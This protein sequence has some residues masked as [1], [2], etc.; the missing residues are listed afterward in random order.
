MNRTTTSSNARF[1]YWPA[2]L[3]AAAALAMLSWPAR[4]H[5]QLDPLLFA[6]R[7][8]PT[9]IVVMDTSFQMLNDGWDGRHDD[10]D[11]VLWPNG[12]I[13][14]TA[15]YRVSDASHDLRVALNLPP[16]ATYY[17]RIYRNF[18]FSTTMPDATQKYTA[19]AI[20]A[21]SD[22]DPRYARFWS[23]T[24][25]E[26]ARLGI[27]DA[28]EH[29]RGANFRWGLY[30]LRQN[31]PALR[32]TCDGPVIVPAGS[33]LAGLTDTGACDGGGLLGI[34][35]TSVA[36][37]NST[38]LS[39]SSTLVPPAANT[40]SQ[41]LTQLGD[42]RQFLGQ[43][44]PFDSSAGGPFA[45]RPQDLIPA[46]LDTQGFE[47]RP[48]TQLLGDIKA[49]ATSAITADTACSNCRNT[50]VVLV[51]AGG[52]HS[53]NP[54]AVAAEFKALAAGG[55]HKVP[56]F[57]VWV[58]PNQHSPNYATDQVQ[59]QTIAD[60]SGGVLIRAWNRPG[61]ARAVNLA[62][63]AGFSRPPD[64]NLQT[65]RRSSEFY[66]VSPVVGTVNLKDARDAT[67]AELP[68][69]TVYTASGDLIPQRN[70]FMLTAGF[71][72]GLAD[73]HAFPHGPGF[74]GRLR[75]FRVFKPVPDS[76][77]PSGY[78]F[79]KDGTPLW[80]DL[81]GRPELANLARVPKNPDS[82]NIYTYIPNVGMVAF[83]PEN[84]AVIEPFLGP[85]HSANALNTSNVAARD[86]ISYIRRQPLGAVIGST[87]AIMDP[88]SLDPPPD[89]DYGRPDAAGTYA[90]D[91][92]DRRSII[93]IGANDGMLHAIDARTGY[94][95]W[96]FI[97]FNLLPKLRAIYEQGQPV[98]QFNYYMD[99][100]PKIAEIKTSDGWR[101]YLVIGEGPG[102]TFYQAFDVTEAGMDGP[103]PESDDFEGVLASFASP[104]RV[105]FKWAFPDYRSFDTTYRQD[106]W[107]TST[108]T[109]AGTPT[110]AT[111]GSVYRA[112]GEL[113]T[114]ATM[115][116]KTVGQT[117]SD[118]AVGALNADRSVNVAMVGSGYYPIEAETV[119]PGRG[120]VSAGHAFYLIRMDTGKLLGNAGGGACNGMGCYDV[121][122]DSP[123][124]KNALQADPTVTGNYGSYIAK[125]AYL[126]DLDGKYYR[127]EFD[128]TG[129]IKTPLVVKTTDKPI[130]A[131]SALMYVGSAYRYVFFMT[132][133]D[134][135]PTSP[136]SSGG[137]GQFKLFG[138]QDANGV[139][140]D[141][142]DPIDLSPVT[143]L[144][145]LPVGERPS[146][147]P[148]V[149]GEIVFFTTTVDVAPACSTELAG[150]PVD[151][152]HNLY[153][154]TYQGTGAY[155]GTGVSSGKK[156]GGGN[157]SVLFNTGA[158]RA[159]APFIVDQH[160]Y[161]ATSGSTGPKVEAFGDPNDFNNGV[162]QVGVRILSW[163]EI[164]R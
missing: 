14:D 21:I 55:G 97:P 25:Y 141:S 76:T 57:V 38:G 123:S 149:A 59:L 95:V 111:P 125:W 36:G 49:A 73:A 164:R 27:R 43:T 69:H 158:G 144:G 119:V 2:L 94:E 127:F 110:D 126:G 92:K 44:N 96:A 137:T 15:T 7:V 67:G 86:L 131:S 18:Q 48:L 52:D 20:E 12:S 30:K 28:V 17:R 128:E 143:N 71:G 91:H 93:W 51:T 31:Q 80:P 3:A 4:A 135:L 13:Y 1:S 81:D 100:S 101:S 102:G 156:G 83:T 121:G 82:R 136:S 106:I 22:L 40:A 79:T 24:R 151:T 74:Y 19:D 98:E 42:D 66:P 88:P 47:D 140:S 134:L 45:A 113:R 77:K 115:A 56:I 138:V 163:R 90:G 6:K 64:F 161:F 129:R 112:Y 139:F 61:V 109:P 89:D 152:M 72:L 154:L 145:G 54:S 84:H 29:N 35:A 53:A 78:T 160:L 114:S 120:G 99:Q 103:P 68:N 162:G 41:I 39:T 150:S 63:Q 46:G 33:R 142:F 58:R 10:S 155:L 130:Y 62:L 122:D 116:E 87:P 117:W 146:T 50:V 147:S 132:G 60:S 5:A 37:L 9:V 11:A 70:N 105:Q 153:A 157:T 26:I 8:P 75:A 148:A 124:P 16:N 104:S 118:P 107:L 85:S 32:T 34:F 23:P 159:T 108:G 133:S 65:E